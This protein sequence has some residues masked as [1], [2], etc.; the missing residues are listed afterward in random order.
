MYFTFFQSH[1][2]FFPRIPR[3]SLLVDAYFFICQA[4]REKLKAGREALREEDEKRE[5]ALQARLGAANSL[6]GDQDR[7]RTR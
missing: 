5:R 1:T 7:N 2:S 6:L 3:L 4:L